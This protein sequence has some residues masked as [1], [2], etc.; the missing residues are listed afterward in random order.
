VTKYSTRG[1]PYNLRPSVL[2]LKGRYTED[3]RAQIEK[4]CKLA[5]GGEKSKING[6]KTRTGCTFSFHYSAVSL[7]FIAV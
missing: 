2:M 4:W 7:T 5:R 3:K 6:R 1:A